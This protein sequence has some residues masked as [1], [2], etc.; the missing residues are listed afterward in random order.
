MKPISLQTWYVY[1]VSPI[2]PLL[3]LMTPDDESHLVLPMQTTSLF[4]IHATLISKLFLH[5]LH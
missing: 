2:K 4:T 5:R 3:Y 1:F